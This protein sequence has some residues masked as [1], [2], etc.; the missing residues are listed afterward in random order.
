[1]S[2]TLPDLID[3]GLNLTHESFDVDRAAVLERAQ[4]AGVGRMILT[5]ATQEG[6]HQAAELARAHPGRLF[7]TAGIHPHHAKEVNTDTAHQLKS[8][9]ACPE[10]VAVGECGLDWFRDFSPRP[11]QEKVFIEQL[12]MAVENRLPLF[13]HQRD[14]SDAFLSI[15]RD[16]RPRITRAV[17]HC[18]TD[19]RATLFGLLDLDCHIGIT[20]WICDERRGRHLKELVPSIPSDR[21]MIETDAPYLIPRDLD[22]KP[23]TQRNEPMHLAHIAAV[24][25]R[26]VEKPLTQLA[27]E[28]TQVAEAF[29]GLDA[30]PP[31]QENS[32]D[33]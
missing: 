4:A 16:Y 6:S 21:L 31:S 29:F 15:L 13:L 27:Q 18:F 32:A 3:I 9:L 25:A 1:M 7:A 30:R 19:D 2:D 20:G 22:P 23:K 8:L 17:V 26:C 28:T 10:V 33:S 12:E 5:G 24:I 14:A 11:V